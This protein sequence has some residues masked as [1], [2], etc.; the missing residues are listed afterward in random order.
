[1]NNKHTIE[2]GRNHKVILP[3]VK[4]TIDKMEQEWKKHINNTERK[5]KYILNDFNRLPTN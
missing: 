2:E 3:Y 5:I 4:W 1:M